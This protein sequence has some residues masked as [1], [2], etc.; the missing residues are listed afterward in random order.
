MHD[1]IR[2]DSSNQKA[3]LAELGYQ[4]WFLGESFRTPSFLNIKMKRD[5]QFWLFLKKSKLQREAN[6]I[7]D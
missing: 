1:L 7:A 2:R 4:I 6:R 5:M 3:R